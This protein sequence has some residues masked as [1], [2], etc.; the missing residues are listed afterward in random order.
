M[1]N[2]Q[3]P[4][5]LPVS[6]PGQ[7]QLLDGLRVAREV[8]QG[9]AALTVYQRAWAEVDL[10]L[11]FEVA[12]GGPRHNE[13]RLSSMALA[14]FGRSPPPGGEAPSNVDLVM[15]VYSP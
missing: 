15:S 9:V 10:Q 5:L 4:L 14:I 11:I 12:Q 6:G 2:S 7:W 13:Q 3:S 1:S 8:G